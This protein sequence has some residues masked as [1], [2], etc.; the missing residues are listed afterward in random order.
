MP[1]CRFQFLNR[2]LSVSQRTHSYA[3][4]PEQGHSQQ[5]RTVRLQNQRVDHASMPR[6]CREERLE[7]EEFSV[8]KLEC[9]STYVGQSQFMDGVGGQGQIAG[10]S[11]VQYG[12]NRLK[13]TLA[14]HDV[15]NDQRLLVTT[16]VTSN[17]WG[18]EP[19]NHRHDCKRRG[20]RRGHRKSPPSAYAPATAE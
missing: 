3:T 15:N 9:P 20:G 11:G 17:H 4:A 7:L 5:R 10:E 14:V 12:F 6:N 13:A 16:H 2:D 8:R 19:G 18:W 1:S